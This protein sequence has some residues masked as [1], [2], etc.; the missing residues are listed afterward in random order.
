VTQTTEH[1]EDN[2]VEKEQK[3]DVIN[4]GSNMRN[5][6]WKRNIEIEPKPGDKNIIFIETGCII[7]ESPEYMGLTLN[8]RQVCA[9]ESAARSNPDYKVYLLH[10]CPVHGRLEDSREYVQTVFTYP[11]V[12][13]WKLDAKR[14]LSKTPLENWDFV[15]AIMSS[16]FPVEHASDVLR[17]LSLWK[18]GGTYLDLDFIILR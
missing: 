13:I 8:K 17:L 9:I 5:G 16:S 3:F 4:A 15:A 10:S 18:Y 7:N 14:Y 2:N 11:N 6:S 12:N 1:K